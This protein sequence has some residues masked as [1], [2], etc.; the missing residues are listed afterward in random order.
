MCEF[1]VVKRFD[2]RILFIY[3][4]TFFLWCSFH[5]LVHIHISLPYFAVFSHAL[6]RLF[7]L[8]IMSFL[9]FALLRQKGTE[10]RTIDVFRNVA[11][12][13]ET[14]NEKQPHKW[15]QRYRRTV[16]SFVCVFFL[17]L[18]V[19]CVNFAV[20]SRSPAFSKMQCIAL[21]CW[22]ADRNILCISSGRW[23]SQ[24]NYKQTKKKNT[25]Y[26]NSHS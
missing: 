24:W 19:T 20:D 21:I 5:C 25:L 9:L 2:F 18:K 11:T 13:Q 15:K 23:H 17:I 16:E 3:I 7:V 14:I 8:H 10:K 26:V 12:V 4:F 1:A 6:I 22:F